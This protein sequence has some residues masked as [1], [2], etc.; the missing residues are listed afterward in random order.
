MLGSGLGTSLSLS[1]IV[2]RSQRDSLSEAEHSC[3]GSKR[4]ISTIFATIL[5]GMRPVIQVTKFRRYFCK[6]ECG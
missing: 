2:M 5:R 4:V 6:R 3:L 1:N